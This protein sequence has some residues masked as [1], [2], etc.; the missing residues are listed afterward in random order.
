[1]Q[2]ETEAL[3]FMFD[4]MITEGV[5]VAMGRYYS[6]EKVFE[7]TDD[8]RNVKFDKPATYSGVQEITAS[9]QM[10]EDFLDKAELEIKK[11]KSEKEWNIYSVNGT[12]LSNG[13]LLREAKKLVKKA[14][15]SANYDKETNSYY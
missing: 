1:M 4:E 13:K 14:L 11:R 8:W 9:K 7:G 10:S 2:N 12:L 6:D 15:E 3:E 5:P